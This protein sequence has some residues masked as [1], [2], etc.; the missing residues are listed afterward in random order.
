[1][2]ITPFARRV[3]RRASRSAERVSGRPDRRRPAG[4]RPAR[5]RARR[6]SSRDRKRHAAPSSRARARTSFE[7][8]AQNRPAAAREYAT[9]IGEYGW[10][11]DILYI[12]EKDGKLNA[13]I[14][15]F[16]EYP[17]E[18]SRA[19]RLRVSRTSACI[20]GEKLVFERDA[21]GQA[22]VAVA[23]TVRVQAPPASGRRRSRE[24][25][26]IKPV[27][28]LDEL[29]KRGARR[30]AAGGESRNLR[31]PD[32]VELQDLDPTIKFDIRYATTNNFMGTPFY[33]SAHAFMQRPAA[34]AVVRVHREA[35]RSCGY[36]L[37]IHDAYRPWYVT[38][39]FW[40][41]TPPDKHIFVADPSQGSRHNRGC[42]VDLTLYDLKTG[43]PIAWS[44]AMTSSRDRS[45]P[46]YPGGTS[47]CS[48]GIATCC[49]TRWKREG[50]TVYDSGV[51]AL[52]LQGLAS[53][54]DRHADVRAAERQSSVALSS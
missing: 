10:D 33:S 54:P 34:E 14:E 50:F 5:A 44:A 21:D 7:C 32:L 3:S 49:A 40:D 28:P 47:R 16:F 26:K 20:D 42:A 13:L 38:K 23:G 52:R 46:D 37:L 15:W 1:M 35:A 29:R 48:A 45:Y 2:Y 18:R 4:V 24:T 51:V 9:L 30:E 41:G 27:R 36:G 19:R 39:M 12:R 25:F 6:R 17:L 31:K 22:T 53:L 11:H 8:R 43:A